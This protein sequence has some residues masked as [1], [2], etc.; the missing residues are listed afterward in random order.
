MNNVV[1]IIAEWNDTVPSVYYCFFSF[2]N[3]NGYFSGSIFVNLI[4]KI[5]GNRVDGTQTNILNYIQRCGRIFIAYYLASPEW[6]LFSRFGVKRVV[7]SGYTHSIDNELLLHIAKAHT[8]WKIKDSFADSNALA[9]ACFYRCDESQSDNGY[10][11]YPI[12]RVVST[13]TI[14]QAK[15]E[16]Q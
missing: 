10:A 9:Y 5:G 12:Q 4:L 8:Q 2:F 11:W 14:V 15:N 1:A 7:W 6:A 13:C 3:E 16:R